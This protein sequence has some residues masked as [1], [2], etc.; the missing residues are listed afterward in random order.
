MVLSLRRLPG[1]KGKKA[2]RWQGTVVHI[3]SQHTVSWGRRVTSSGPAWT[4]VNPMAAWEISFENKKRPKSSTVFLKSVCQL[5]CMPNRLGLPMHRP[6]LLPH[7]AVWDM[8]FKDLLLCFIYVGECVYVCVFKHA[9]C[10][11][12]SGLAETRRC[13]IPWKWNDLIWVLKTK[14]G[15][16]ANY[17][18]LVSYLQP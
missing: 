11:S 7:V 16:S 9:T 1:S 18:T 5:S 14:S 6:F 2:E 10:M 4:L 17:F 3:Y 12:V 15:F 13:L 8:D